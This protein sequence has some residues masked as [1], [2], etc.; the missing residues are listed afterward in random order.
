[1]VH[2]STL[3]TGILSC[4]LYFAEAT[5][6]PAAVI[7]C[8]NAKAPEC[9]K[10]HSDYSCLCGH[11]DAILNCLALKS[12]YG[13]YLE[14]RD[15]F[16]GICMERI[17]HLVDDPDF[18]FE[19]GKRKVRPPTSTIQE[20]ETSSISEISRTDNF[21]P[22]DYPNSGDD[23]ENNQE[24]DSDHFHE[25]DENEQE[26]MIDFPPEKEK[27]NKD[28][29]LND[30][31]Q[32]TE[33]DRKC[34]DNGCNCRCYCS[35]DHEFEIDNEEDR[36]ICDDDQSNKI[37][38]SD[39]NLYIEDKIEGDN[40][41]EQFCSN[42]I[43]CEDKSYDDKNSDEFV[44]HIEGVEEDDDDIEEN[45]DYKDNDEF[46]E[47][48]MTEEQEP[49]DENKGQDG[50]NNDGEGEGEDEDE[51]WDRWDMVEDNDESNFCYCYC[52]C[53]NYIEKKVPIT[54]SSITTDNDPSAKGRSSYTASKHGE[55]EP[56]FSTEKQIK[57]S[58]KEEDHYR[59]Q[60]F[61]KVQEDVDDNR[62]EIKN[63]VDFQFATPE[64]V[65]PELLKRDFSIEA[66][67]KKRQSKKKFVDEYDR[68]IRFGSSFLKTEKLP[69]S[70][71]SSDKYRG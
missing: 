40:N 58:L 43:D 5:S 3:V 21:V 2:L 11:R 20:T 61:K 60:P 34:I 10:R 42:P 37:D 62:V 54:F 13:K 53:E 1:M 23:D 48:E 70:V 19:L 69:K 59:G 24:E 64:I 17:P 31:D 8:I 32:N 41:D 46:K 51:I 68:R 26:E 7:H 39:K 16:L 33:D 4:A 29:G 44:D 56:G 63:A 12:P 18:N 38:D 28:D 14:A 66:A 71:A 30:K 67:A 36:E 35:C 65:F 27:E 55:L 47:E 57:Y 25:D 6:P 50:T 15:H 49:K 45:S 52:D 9:T 22:T